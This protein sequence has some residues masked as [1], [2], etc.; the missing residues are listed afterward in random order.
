MMREVVIVEALRTPI[1]RFRGKLQPVRADQLG[2]IVIDAL[3]Q[4]AGID[5]LH[6]EIHRPEQQRLAARVGPRGK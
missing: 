2:A 4:R 1:V 5:A 3:V 6:R